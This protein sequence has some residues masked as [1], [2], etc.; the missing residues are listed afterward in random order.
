MHDLAGAVL[1]LFGEGG[2]ALDHAGVGDDPDFAGHVQAR[3]QDLLTDRLA[4]AA[5]G[6]RNQAFGLDVFEDDDRLIAAH[7]SD[8]VVAQQVA[9][10]FPMDL[11]DALFVVL[12]LLG[13]RI[14]QE[15]G[16]QPGHLFHFLFARNFL[17][18]DVLVQRHMG[19]VAIEDHAVVPGAVD[20]D[21]G[22]EANR[23]ITRR[24]RHH[25]D[26]CNKNGFCD[27]P[28]RIQHDR[29][30]GLYLFGAV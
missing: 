13:R 22:I 12:E 23:Q 16:L 20:L 11:E 24:Q 21:L 2:V 9:L 14:T 18:D 28:R 10:L 26:G 30:Q 27:G 7:K 19:Q 25:E 5:G 29:S 6:Y 8:H 4:H 1:H 3:V 15:I 17:A